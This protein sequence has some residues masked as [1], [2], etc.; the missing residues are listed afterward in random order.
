MP[1]TS[2]KIVTSPKQRGLNESFSFV[3]WV[4]FVNE[5]TRDSERSLRPKRAGNDAVKP[6]FGL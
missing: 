1:T 5:L 3:I 6:R 2:A 4:K